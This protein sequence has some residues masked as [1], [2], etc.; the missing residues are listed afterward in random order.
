MN[1][2]CGDSRR[3]TLQSVS[4]VGQIVVS[5][6]SLFILYRVLLQN[7]GVTLLGVWSLV[8][9]VGALAQ[10]A[11]LGLS[12]SVV[13]FAAKYAACGE[14][15]TV[16]KVVSTAATSTALLYCI[17]LAVGYPIIR[18]L[19]AVALPAESLPLAFQVL[20]HAVCAFWIAA[21]ASVYQAGL[22]GCRRY[23]SRNLILA[24]DTLS[25]LALCAILTPRYGLHG[26]A[27]ARVVQNVLT[28]IA[29]HVALSRHLSGSGSLLPVWDRSL[30]VEMFRYAV[31]FQVVAILA[32]LFEPM[33]KGLLSRFGS[34]AAVG[35][36]EMASR[37]V[38]QVRTLIV[39]AVQ[40]MVPYLTGLHETAPD[41]VMQAYTRAYE[42]VFFLSV[43]SFGALIAA[44]PLI[45]GI[46]IGDDT[47]PFIGYAALM[48]FGW[49]L[50]TICLP[51]YFAG[52]GSGKLRWNVISHVV[53]VSAN[54]LL[55]TLFGSLF[56]GEGVVTAWAV[57]LA[58][59]GAVVGV[60]YHREHRISLA[61]LIPPAGRALAAACVAGIA[62]AYGA[63]LVVPAVAMPVPAGCAMVVLFSVSV[64]W[65][66]WNNPT[67]RYLF[68]HLVAACRRQ[69]IAVD[70]R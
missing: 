45:A 47:G 42:V 37:L 48:A 21:V 20:P 65:T 39:G 5:A 62:V 28:F 59:G 13:R 24:S 53:M 32:L 38:M 56:G 43:S 9:S 35:Y 25:Y 44:I 4:S 7:I 51:A 66:F 30:F 1:E 61:A 29:C 19:L 14:T 57:S 46:W 10:V 22:E 6:V 27:W 11:Q 60:A 52:L 64:G 63:R 18:L 3:M 49:C 54:A 12:G 69:S 67:R 70:R 8:L 33:T 15:D 34:V 36:F 2:R 16:G 23:L 40:V 31:N 58:L 26:L 41:R 50:N 17:V 55:G 68:D